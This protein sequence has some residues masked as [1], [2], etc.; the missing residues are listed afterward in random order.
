MLSHPADFILFSFA[1][2]D[3]ATLALDRV[4]GLEQARL[5]PL[6]PE[7]DA[8]CGFALRILPNDFDR[9]LALLENKGFEST[10]TLK[11]IDGRRKV[12]KYVFR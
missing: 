4:Q 10:Y 8:G 5:I 3:E 12:E 9:V 2:T 6:P 1:S 11:K 7:I